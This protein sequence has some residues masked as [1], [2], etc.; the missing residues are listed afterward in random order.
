MFCLTLQVNIEGRGIVIRLPSG[1]SFLSS[2]HGPEGLW[3]PHSRQSCGFHG[4]FPG[5]K[6]LGRE[7]HLSPASNTKVDNE[8]SHAKTGQQVKLFNIYM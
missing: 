3:G 1:Q 5:V 2:P 4:L 8:L 7:S 6:R